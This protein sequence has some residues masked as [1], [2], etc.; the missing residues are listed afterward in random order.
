VAAEV[1][2]ASFA[3]FVGAI[4]RALPLALICIPDRTSLYIS[5]P[6]CIDYGRFVYMTA[7]RETMSSFKLDRL[8]LR[9][10]RFETAAILKRLAAASRQLAELKGVAASIPHQGILVNTLGMQE[11]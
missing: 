10:E 1:G 8:R 6:M 5:A 3:V 9:P 2:Q 7:P 4:K 11:A